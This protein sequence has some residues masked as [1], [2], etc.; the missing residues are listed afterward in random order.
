MSENKFPRWYPDKPPIYDIH[1]TYLNNALDGPIFSETIPVR[2]L[3]PSEKWID[4]FGFKIASPIGI[5][6]GP[7]L[8]AKWI[9]LAANL[10]YD[11]VTYKTI[12]S[13]EYHSHPLPNMVYVDT[14]GPVTSSNQ[15]AEKVEKPP[16]EIE[17]LAVTNSFGMPSMT[18]E[19]LMEDIPRAH[20]YLKQGQVMIVSVVGTPRP[21]ENFRD[22]FVKAALLAKRAGAQI[23]E[24]NFSCPNV[25][26]REG[27]L[28]T[29]PDTVMEIGKAIVKAIHPIPLILK[30]GVFSS[31]EQMKDV[32]VA[33][34]KTG[35]QGICGINSVSMQVS[36]KAGEPALGP[37]RLTSGICGGPIRTAAL[38]F[39]SQATAII[40]KEKLDLTLLGC[41]GITA[42]EHFDEFLLAGALIAMTATGMIWDPYLALRYHATHP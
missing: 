5:P 34:A 8:S 21:H 15:K 17:D 16:K 36:G 4:F 12:R 14:H 26:K 11:V 33:A 20:G 35:T 37:N 10:G 1:K 18:P 6:A 9:K 41:G 29:S 13:Q 32:L 40:Q 24:A 19:F 42:P 7:L 25:E 39:L 22:D 27:S 28:Y 23:I 30:M 2:E 31:K 3:P 38:Q